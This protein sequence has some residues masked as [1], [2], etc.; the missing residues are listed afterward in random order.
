MKQLLSIEWIKIKKLKAAWIIIFAY[1]LLVPVWMY[2]WNNI[3]GQLNS[4]LPAPIFPSTKTLWSFPTVWKFVTYAASYFNLLLSVLIVI[5]T[6]N[7]FSNRTLR[8]HIIDGLSKQKVITSKFLVIIGL[9]VFVTLYCFMISLIFGLT[10]GETIDFWENIEYLGLFFIQSLC[11]FGFAFLLGI[12]IKK[13]ALSIILFYGYIFVEAI[14][15]LF[16]PA[17]IYAWFP[18]NNFSKLTPLPFFETLSNQR[19]D[20][21]ELVIWPM[22]Q[23]VIVSLIFLTLIYA[24]AYLRLKRKDL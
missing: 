21:G 17:T 16:L 6:A 13:S 2:A 3:F 4:S 5:L 20:L 7:E 23:N 19:V 10:Q 22:Y 24:T 14:V 8:Q 9:A 15:G 11:Y 1:M 12:L 18:A